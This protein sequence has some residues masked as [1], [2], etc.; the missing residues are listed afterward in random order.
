MFYEAIASLEVVI[1]RN[2]AV[3]MLITDGDYEIRKCWY[4]WPR[5]N[6]RGVLQWDFNFAKTVVPLALVI[7]WNR[8][9]KPVAII[10]EW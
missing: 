10:W 2:T 3:K 7:I 5:L 8:K 9:T 1:I 6:D 4:K